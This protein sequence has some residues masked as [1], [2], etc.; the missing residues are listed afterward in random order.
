ML[1]AGPGLQVVGLQSGRPKSGR[2]SFIPGSQLSENTI[3]ICPPVLGSNEYASWCR[4]LQVDTD[5]LETCLC[6]LHLNT[7]QII[8]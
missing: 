3:N 4:E 1:V 8:F 7:H 5:L 6:R 2:P